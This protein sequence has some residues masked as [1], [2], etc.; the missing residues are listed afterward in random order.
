MFEKLTN[1]ISFDLE[2]LFTNIPLEECIDLAFRYIYKGNSHLKLTPSDL[3]RHFSFVTDEILFC[4]K[5]PF[6]T[7]LTGLP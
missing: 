5:V 1:L 2:T 7:R 4:S 6:T 3:K